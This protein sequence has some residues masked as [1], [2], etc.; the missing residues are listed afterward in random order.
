MQQKAAL[1]AGW[2]VPISQQR[3]RVNPLVFSS[4]SSPQGAEH[5]D[6]K[7][8]RKKMTAQERKKR[9]KT[10][11]RMKTSKQMGWKSNFHICMGESASHV[12]ILMPCGKFVNEVTGTDF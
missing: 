1:Q 2:R 7:K 11:K 3:V 9:E 10:L 8:K 5:A 4:I 12:K 6:K